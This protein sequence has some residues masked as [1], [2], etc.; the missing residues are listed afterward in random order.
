MLV[1]TWF[2]SFLEG[3]F[4]YSGYHGQTGATALFGQS[5]LAAVT[6]GLFSVFG[7]FIAVRALVRKSAS[8]FLLVVAYLLVLQAYVLQTIHYKAIM[9][10]P[11]CIFAIEYLRSHEHPPTPTLRRTGR[12]T[13][14]R[15]GH[16]FRWWFVLLAMAMITASQY[17]AVLATALSSE[18]GLVRTLQA[19]PGLSFYSAI[20]YNMC[21][22]VF[23]AV[24]LCSAGSRTGGKTSGDNNR[25]RALYPPHPTLSLWERE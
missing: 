1:P 19:M 15:A 14:W 8:Q 16:R 11:M 24:V 10:A 21:L 3:I 12:R 20:F 2:S 17:Y 18:H 7:V 5:T 25:T 6:S 9:A 22:A 13:G 4:A 23:L